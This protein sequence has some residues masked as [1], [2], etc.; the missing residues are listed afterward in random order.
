MNLPDKLVSQFAKIL[1]PEP[2]K[3]KEETVYGTIVQQGLTKF[4]KIDGSDYLTPID[5]TVDMLNGERVTVL[6]KNHTAIVTGNITSP[7]ARTGSVETAVSDMDKR[8]EYLEK[9]TS[10]EAIVNVIYPIG[11][12]YLSVNETSPET[13]F[14]GKWEQIQD[15]FLLA[16]GTRELGST[17]GEE[18]HTLT[19]NEMPAHTHELNVATNKT[20][21]SAPS[22]GLA[23]LDLNIMSFETGEVVSVTEVGGGKPHNNMPPYLV[24]NIWKR[25]E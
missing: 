5:T 25:I 16:S 3:R 7:A 15:R 20:T 8:Y 17:G 1:K 21:V 4:V 18:E 10:Y 12:L 14:G 23:N 11:S 19:I 6:I 2:V 24:V 22:D 9:R 13:L